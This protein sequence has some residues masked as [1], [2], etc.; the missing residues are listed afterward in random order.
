LGYLIRI[1]MV[2]GVD[3]CSMM[4]IRRMSNSIDTVIAPRKPLGYTP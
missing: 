4:D 3:R 1:T 2:D